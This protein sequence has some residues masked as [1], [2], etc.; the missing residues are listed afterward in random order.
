MSDT[1]KTLALINATLPGVTGPKIIAEVDD[2]LEKNIS[3]L[4]SP[5]LDASLSSS[6]SA[7]PA[8]LVGD[9]K[10]AVTR[11]NSIYGKDSKQTLLTMTE[12]IP[13]KTVATVSNAFKLVD[14]TGTYVLKIPTS[15]LSTDPF[16]I[17]HPNNMVIVGTTYQIFWSDS[18]AFTTSA[19][20][21]FVSDAAVIRRSDSNNGNYAYIYVPVSS[22]TPS[23]VINRPLS[24]DEVPYDFININHNNQTSFSVTANSGVLD[25][26]GSA[27]ISNAF[28]LQ[29]TL[30]SSDSINL[31]IY[32][33]DG[34]YNTKI[35]LAAGTND[36][37]SYNGKIGVIAKSGDKI[38]S[39]D[40]TTRIGK[41]NSKYLSP[42]NNW[43]GKTL[44]CYGDSITEQGYWQ[45]YLNRICGF[46]K[47]INGGHSGSRLM[48]LATDE[49]IDA[50]TDTFDV[51][52][53][54]AGVNDWTQDRSIG[55]IN[56]VNTDD[57]SFT[58]T[59]YGGLNKMLNKLTTK[60]PARRFV[61]VTPTY[62]YLNDSSK[63]FNGTGLGDVNS[64][65]NTMRDFADAMIAAC[66]KWNVPCIDLL[67]QIGW[68][69]N[70][71]S[72]YVK[73]DATTVG[74][75]TYANYSHPDTAGA[76]I[77]A[78]VIGNYL[79]TIIPIA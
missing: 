35:V 62:V 20:R 42:A 78:G 44:Y 65:G 51:M 2:W 64:N 41:I 3:E 36:T 66:K 47:L 30:N 50:I 14:N 10:S 6:E 24:D 13:N 9:L 76:K 70:N 21:S 16:L 32:N 68:N 75:E 26:N 48:L 33:T 45:P 49:Y 15:V 77:M 18:D 40:S 79:Q 8:N 72:T 19:R 56:D 63:F 52:V 12:V 7:A 73:N 57:Q 74:T 28:Y 43:N 59:F 25:Y 1:G 53:V 31:F 29:N 71:I 54:M 22:A 4:S 61:F 37:S 34:S 27:K 46:S 5:P 38:V 67:S 23:Y 55:T 17:A 69:K 60:W 11:I 39:Y 58:G